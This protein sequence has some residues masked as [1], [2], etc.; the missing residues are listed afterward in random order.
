LFENTHLPLQWWFHA[1]YLFMR[2]PQG[3]PAKELE[4]QLAVPYKTAWRMAREIRIHMG[5]SPVNAA[6]FLG[7]EDDKRS[8]SAIRKG[9]NERDRAGEGKSVI[10]GKNFFQS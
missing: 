5:L 6:R 2:S 8:C 9:R 3:L 4:R 10:F 1:I 7:R